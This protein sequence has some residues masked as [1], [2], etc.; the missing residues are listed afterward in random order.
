MPCELIN[1][2]KE[3]AR[4]AFQKLGKSRRNMKSLQT[5]EAK[6]ARK[7]DIDFIQARIADLPKILRTIQKS[8][9]VGAGVRT[10]D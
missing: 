3:N 9:G 4:K 5:E 2:L 10:K 1:D 8:K 6:V 7:M